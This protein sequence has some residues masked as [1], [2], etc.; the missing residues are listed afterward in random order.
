MKV[1]LF[2][3]TM[4]SFICSSLC[5]SSSF[6]FQDSDGIRWKCQ[7]LDENNVS[8]KCIGGNN[9]IEIKTPV[10]VT[11]EGSTYMVKRIEQECF[12]LYEDEDDDACPGYKIYTKL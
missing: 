7:I 8:I 3:L 10:F 1:K 2:L 5:W 11:N 4:M 12:D 9:A 6:N